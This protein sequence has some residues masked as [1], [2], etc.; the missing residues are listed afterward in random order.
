MGC[1]GVAII[2]KN[3]NKN[4]SELEFNFDIKDVEFKTVGSECNGCPNNCE[5]VSIYKNNELIDKMGG[6]CQRGNA[7]KQNA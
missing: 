5:I 7:I 6:R 3:M 4:G 1:L 2:S